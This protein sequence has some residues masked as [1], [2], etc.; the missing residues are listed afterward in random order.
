[1]YPGTLGR[2]L[3]SDASDQVFTRKMLNKRKMWSTPCVTIV[4][5]QNKAIAKIRILFFERGFLPFQTNLFLFRHV[6]EVWATDDLSSPPSSMLFVLPLLPWAS[7][8]EGWS[9]SL[10]QRHKPGGIIQPFPDDKGVIFLFLRMAFDSQK[11]CHHCVKTLMTFSTCHSSVTE[12]D[13]W[14]SVAQW[15]VR[16]AQQHEKHWDI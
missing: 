10:H 16:Q 8:T 12:C 7:E 6:D 5:S 1:M 9:L 14:I 11:C 2:S 15:F 3:W 4:W 13:S